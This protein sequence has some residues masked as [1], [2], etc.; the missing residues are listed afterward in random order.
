MLTAK[1]ATVALDAPLKE[2]LQAVFAADSVASGLLH[3]LQ[4]RNQLVQE[5]LTNTCNIPAA[6]LSIQTATADSLQNYDSSAKYK[7]DMQLPNNN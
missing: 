7:I 4:Q 2:K 5:Y 1:G 6:K 3:K